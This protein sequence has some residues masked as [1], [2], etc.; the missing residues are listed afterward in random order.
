MAGGLEGGMTNG[1]P[2]SET[3]NDAA[4]LTMVAMAM[5]A[6]SRPSTPVRPSSGRKTRMMSSALMSMN[7]PISSSNARISAMIT[8]AVSK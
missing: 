2:V 6:N 1:E 5:G 8:A 7:M 4:M 3:T